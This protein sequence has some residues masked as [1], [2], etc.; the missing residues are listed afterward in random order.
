MPMLV[1]HL[2]TLRT[3][4][5]SLHHGPIQ[6]TLATNHAGGFAVTVMPPHPIRGSTLNPAECGLHQLHE[7]LLYLGRGIFPSKR[8]QQRMRLRQSEVN[9]VT[10]VTDRNSAGNSFL[11]HPP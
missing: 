2:P 3:A 9:V 6:N 8:Q 7:N 4:S 1:P 5:R 11:H 10:P